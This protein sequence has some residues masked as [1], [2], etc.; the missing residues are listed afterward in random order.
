M[1]LRWTLPAAE[2]LEAIR[3]YLEKNHPEFANSTVRTIYD[4]VRSL[5]IMHNRGRIGLKSGTRELVFSPL[6]YIVTYRVTDQA[7]EVLRIHH[8][9]QDR[10]I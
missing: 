6:P 5:K 9:A 8:G 7:V 3:Q 2:D 4:G 10:S 1:R